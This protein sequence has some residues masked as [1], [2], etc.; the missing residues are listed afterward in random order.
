[1][2]GYFITGTDTGVGKTIVTACLA[3]LFKNRNVG[4]MKPIETGVDPECSSSSNSDAKFL[5]EVTGVPDLLEDVCPYR[6]KLSAS[7]YQAA[8]IEGKE[9]DPEIIL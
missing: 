3:K 7:P 4:V 2:E 8:R 9:I 1:M 5:M 6:L